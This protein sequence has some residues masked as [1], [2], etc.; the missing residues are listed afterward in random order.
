MVWGIEWSRDRLC[1][2]ILKGQDHD[3]IDPPGDAIATIGLSLICK[4]AVS[5]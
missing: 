1:H 2:M 3:P 4:S 5:L